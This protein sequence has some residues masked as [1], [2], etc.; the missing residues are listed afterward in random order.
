MGLLWRRRSELHSDQINA[1]EGLPVDGKYLLIGPPGSGKT[2]ILLHRGQ[3]V[4]GSSVGHGN[5]RMVTFARTLREFIAINGD[6]RFPPEL[7]QTLAS[8]VNEIFEA[9]ETERPDTSSARNLP[10][11]NEVRSKAANNLLSSDPSRVEYE[12]ILA[13]EV[14]DLCRDEVSLLDRLSPRQMLSGDSRQKLYEVEGAIDAI[15]GLGYQVITLK[16]HF[17]I[18]PPICLVAD[19]ISVIDGYKLQDWCRYT[20][21]APTAPQIFSGIARQDQIKKLIEYLDIQFDTYNDPEDLIGIV[22][23]RKED[24]DLVAD[25]LEDIEKFEG[26]VGVFHSDIKNRRFDSGWKI[27]VLTLQ[28]CKGLEF[29]ALHWLFVD[30]DTRLSRSAAYTVVTRAKTSL[31]VYHHGQVRSFLAGAFP[32]RGGGLF[33]DDE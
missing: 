18:S 30:E 27:C 32:S 33:E 5:I 3:Y 2:S 31:N 17:R 11:A 19:N 16:H 10:Q 9:F 4:R 28:S 6:D 7:I 8:F 1:I 26:K 23:Q 12:L 21:P 29:R 24:C 25:L 13:D 14:Q 22:V 15:K 20:G